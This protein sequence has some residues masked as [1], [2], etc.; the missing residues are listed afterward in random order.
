MHA[1]EILS[2]RI[3]LVLL[4]VLLLVLGVLKYKQYQ[5]Q[6]A[7]ELEKQTLMAQEDSLQK[8]NS[9]LKDSLAQL[10]SEQYK[11]RVAREDLNLKKEGEIV[12]N[13][14]LFADNQ[15]SSGPKNATEKISNP[16]K[17]WNYFFNHSR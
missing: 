11:E 3:T 9:E 8:K 6:Q 13:F 5:R 12:Y 2:S 10:S 4:A 17:W 14:S 1:R 16:R 15:Q 7:I